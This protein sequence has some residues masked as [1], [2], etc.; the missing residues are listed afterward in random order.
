MPRP[1]RVLLLNERDAR[2]PQAGGAEVHVQALFSRLA[3]RGWEVSQLAS[4]FSGAPGSETLDGLK[5][6]RLGPLPA[7]YPRAVWT[8]ARETRRRRFDVVVECLNKVP[9]YAPL[10]AAVPV[11]AIAHHL[12]GSTAFEQ[13]TWPVAAAV[14]ALELPLPR[15]YRRVPCVAI[16]ESTRDDL[17][18]R[19]L[20]PERIRVS[21]CGVEPA[22]FEPPPMAERP[23]RI[24][25]LGRLEPY[26]RI[27]RAL[28]ALALLAPRHPEL[29]LLVIGRGSDRPR[30][31][32]LARELGVA[33]RTRFT[34]YVSRAERDAL[35]ASCRAALCTSP[36]EG[37]GLVVVEANAVGTPVVATDAPGLRD[38]VDP[39]KTGFLVPGSE[40][41]LVADAVGRL[42]AD[43]ALAEQMSAAALTWSRRFCWDRAADEMAQVLE[44]AC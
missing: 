13:V 31:E 5:V 21:H 32:G 26:K 7:Y 17:L 4:G 39:D 9:F 10:H 22:D 40:P 24:A 14:Y 30:L 41:A 2:H 19:G 16:S 6:R 11:V 18:R 33:G 3:A 35:L 15:V 12:F 8:C 23:A 38:S 42:L 25:C 28:R 1:P 36:K 43:D 29:E 27:D 20:P 44:A 37:W 34:G